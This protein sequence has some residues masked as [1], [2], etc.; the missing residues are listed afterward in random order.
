M[1]AYLLDSA[2]AIP[3]DE[4]IIM[5]HETHGLLVQVDLFLPGGSSYM[6]PPCHWLGVNL[7]EMVF[8]QWSFD[9][10]IL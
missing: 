4:K 3:A 1:G 7:N 9:L 2:L 10:W 5:E 6:K 8:E